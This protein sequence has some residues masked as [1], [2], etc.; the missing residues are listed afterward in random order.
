[1]AEEPDESTLHESPPHAEEEVLIPDEPPAAGEASDEEDSAAAAEEG[2]AAPE[3]GEYEEEEE[4][5]EAAAEEGEYGEEG[6][7]G[8]EEEESEAGAEEGEYEE[9]SEAAA[10]EGEYEE[11]IEPV[12]EEGENE[13]SEAVDEEAAG[14]ME[15]EP[16][17]QEAEVAAAA[18]AGATESESLLQ[19]CTNCA[20]LLDV[21]EHEPFAKVHCPICGT[22]M[23]VRT[24]LK[25][26]T[27]VEVLGAGGMGAVYK[28]LD[29]NLN[30]MVAL[31]VVRK[32]YS[33][34]AE[35]LGK[36][37]R[38]ARITA[39][40]N[41]P[42]VVKVYSFG[43]DHGLF[44][45]AMELVDKGSLD[46]LMNLQGRVAEIQALGVG[47]QM[48]QGLQAA[49]QKGLIH[50]DVKPGNILFADAQTAKI[51]DFGLALLA[52]HEAEERGE[53][54]GTPYYVAPE[55][56]DHQPEDFRSDMYSLGGTLFHAIAGRPPFEADTASMVALKHL[57]SKAVSL[58]AFAPDVSSAT[59][60]VINRTLHKEPDQRYQSYAE[61]IEH[62]EYAKSQLLE[63][64]T[65]PRK[66]RQRVVVESAG[67][68]KVLGIITLVLLLLVVCI[69]GGLYAF[70]D[71][72]FSHHEA[73]AGSSA[74]DP[75]A[76]ASQMHARL[77]A[78]RKQ[79]VAGDY[80]G[81]TEALK[82]LDDESDITQPFQ[83]WI[84]VNEGLAALLQE[85]LRD[86]QD[87]FNVVGERSGFSND[88][89]DKPLVDFFSKIAKAMNG[90]API[91]PGAG[92][93]YALDSVEALAP[94]LFALKDW[95]LGRF[96]D[97]GKLLA[98]FLSSNPKDPF[99]WV[100]DYKP[101]AQKYADDEAAYEQAGAAAAAA[102]TPDK[103]AEALKQVTG[104]QA[105]VKGKLAAKLGK[106]AA[107]LKKKSA[108]L[109][110]SYNQRMAQAQQHDLSV[111]DDAKRKY[112]AFCADFRFTDAQA[113]VQASSVSTPDATKER[114][115]LLKKSAWLCQ[116]KAL[117]I[118]DI[119]AH[120]YPEVL[121]TR[122]GGRLPDG[123]KRAD[124]NELL[125][126][127][128]F[129]S[130]PC[131]WT[132]LP[133][134]E[135]LALSNYFDQITATSAPRQV[136]DR[137]WLS[138]VF[139]CEE[140]LARDGH[141]LLVQASQVKDEYKDELSLFMDSE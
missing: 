45:I 38:E 29:T 69:G 76:A 48:A 26:F 16:V 114:D 27:L 112:A 116:F 111:L 110:A 135:I 58:Q 14:E 134:S 28:A 125:V 91:S 43:S 56:L 70:R 49:H 95:N 88:P 100:A 104:I 35:Y 79:I 37:E 126:Q 89:S 32:E 109:D 122:S 52:E 137:Q 25:N 62:L 34:D 7:A 103:R 13:G 21:G 119:N 40:V 132:T 107:D 64:S 4:E 67:Q 120:G 74:E 131:P 98:L 24:Q 6:E 97:A 80:A 106:I 93:G 3:E 31:K 44:Y 36:F 77:D 117:L 53:V 139:A 57:K 2:E 133:P 42:N 78:A 60:Y 68:Q 61:L 128:Q 12:A 71:R 9:E 10:E 18:A 129:G 11:E 90:S 86:A 30:R 105:R 59:A 141:T 72:I 83:N 55:K 96:E 65:G 1:M 19:P 33:S 47:I 22:A 75:E 102:N 115:G 108:A 138:G 130:V 113:A 87:W 17:T 84:T 123:P 136:P 54:W 101:L 50:R 85:N 39:S 140:G 15:G 20:T 82:S 51:V 121:V 94:L 124:D 92:S 8:A 99:E 66:A 46:D 127:T 5:D 41:H 81:A 23:R 63:A 73:G 118:Q